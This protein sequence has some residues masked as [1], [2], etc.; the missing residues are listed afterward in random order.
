MDADRKSS[1]H[2]SA[3][4]ALRLAILA[5]GTWQLSRRA[6]Q[7]KSAKFNDINCV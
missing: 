3:R 2:G 1:D 7:V 4:S 6:Q 5:S